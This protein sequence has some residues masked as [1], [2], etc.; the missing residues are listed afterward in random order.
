MNRLSG[1]VSIGAQDFAQLIE[2]GSFYIDRTSFLREWF[3][4]MDIVTLITRP[5]RFGKTLTLSM[6]DRFFSD[7][8]GT[9]AGLFQE[10]DISEYPDM[11][12]LKGTFPVVNATFADVKESD[13][14]GFL[15][16]CSSIVRRL[17]RRNSYL[18]KSPRVS[19]VNKRYMAGVIEE[20]F[21]DSGDIIPLS[22]SVMTDALQRLMQI[23]EEDSG[24]KVLFLLDE[25]D[26]P[27]QEAWIHDYWDE[28]A[29]FFRRLFNAALKTNDALARALLTGITRVAKESIFSDLNNLAVYT[30]SSEKYAEVFG[31]TEKEVMS[32]LAA[33][34]LSGEAE[35]IRK[36]YDGFTFGTKKDI[37]N[38]WSVTSFLNY[39]IYKP[40]WANSSSNQLV[41]SLI[42]N[43]N[44]GLSHEV[45]ELLDGGTIKARIDDEIVFSQLG[46]KKDSVWSLLLAAGYVKTESA[47]GE[48]YTLSLTN[49]EVMK[50]FE[51]MAEGWFERDDGNYGYF[52]RYLL[53][54]DEENVENYLRELL[55][56]T[57]SSFDGG[58]LPSSRDPEKFYHG[59]VLGMVVTLRGRYAV[60][61]NR[62]SGF[63]R[64]DIA[65]KP[66]H[67]DEDP[68]ILIECK[69]FDQKKEKKLEE[70][71][72]RALLQIREK[73]Y[74]AELTDEGIEAARTYL[75]G[76]AFSGKEV[77]VRKA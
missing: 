27:L 22:E 13:Y 34:G 72:E 75:Y 65:L 19:E 49:Y 2:S 26:T 1:E 47:A 70:T 52:L 6:V 33:R 53:A 18:E 59:L 76:F 39:K 32:S 36:W 60:R 77:C 71:A 50:F 7:R 10:L 46:R 38:P 41:S 48:D 57:V 25:Y 15:R 61:S 24:K 54:G 20:R 73:Q 62:E 45:R 28:A 74:D 4:G 31:F 9:D 14:E 51:D 56:N 11:M 30:V 63:G 66:L 58:L 5:R 29:S 67:G 44:T 69:L 42:W 68:A 40:Y 8:Y 3:L 64:Y 23:M 35:N 17:F 12:A 21:D 43:G 37:Y 55:V 16:K